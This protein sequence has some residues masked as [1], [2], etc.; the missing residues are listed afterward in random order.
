MQKTKTAVSELGLADEGCVPDV[1]QDRSGG[2][3][4]PAARSASPA[5]ELQRAVLEVVGQ[6][7][8]RQD[9][10]HALRSSVVRHFRLIAHLPRR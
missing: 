2:C 10:P 3:R 9:L 8:A 5:A 1:A 6:R 7:A 4:L